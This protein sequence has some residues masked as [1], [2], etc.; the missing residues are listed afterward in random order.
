[1]DSMHEQLPP[2]RLAGGRDEPNQQPCYKHGEQRELQWQQQQWRQEAA[3]QQGDAGGLEGCLKSGKPLFLCGKQQQQQQGQQGQQPS[4]FGA[5]YGQVTATD[6]AATGNSEVT[7]MKQQG[8]GSLY[9]LTYELCG[10][11]EM[12]FNQ[13]QTP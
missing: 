4:D 10:G 12:S 8:G 6:D 5:R 9:P 13:V 1:M 2:K 3:F 7:V 11:A